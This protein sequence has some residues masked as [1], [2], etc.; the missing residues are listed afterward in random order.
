M[1]IRTDIDYYAV[2][3]VDKSS[4]EADI[5]AAFI[6]ASKKWHPDRNPG[7]DTTRKMQEINEAR[8]ILL[9]GAKRVEY[10]AR[11]SGSYYSNSNGNEYA[12][13]SESR[14]ERNLMRYEKLKG[15]VRHL[16]SVR[17]DDFETYFYRIRN[18][19]VQQ[20]ANYCTHWYEYNIDFLDMVVIELHEVRNYDLDAIYGL[21]KPK[22]QPTSNP[23]PKTTYGE[24]A[25]EKGFPWWL[26]WLGIVLLNAILRR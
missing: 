25:T 19:S 17:P 22:P 4:S 16:R 15:R 14:T 7:I 18:T 9:D 21:M 6:R 11:R 23:N 2:L 8:D 13:Y 24:A 5:K 10:D 3:E 20:L 26:L 12:T 1:A